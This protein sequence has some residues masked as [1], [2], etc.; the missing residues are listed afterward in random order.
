VY[1]TWEDY[2]GKKILVD[3]STNGGT[4]WSTDHLVTNYRINTTSFFISIPPQPNRGVLPMPMTAVAPAGTAC[5]GRLYVSY[6]DKAPTTANTNIYLKYSDDGGVT[7][8]SEIKVN[9]DT[10][11]AYHFHNAIAVSPNGTVGIEFY[12]TRNDQ[13]LNHKTDQYISFS[14]DCGVTWSANQKVTTAMS[15]ESGAGDPNDYGDYQ[16]LAASSK[17]FFQASWTDSRVGAKAE[18]MFSA[19]S[20]P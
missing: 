19:T 1:A 4:T 7:W 17:N 6:F 10:V 14:T 16:G 18:D 9:D 12:D 11:N 3:R 2:S 8:S 13:P 5:A 20:K 15:D